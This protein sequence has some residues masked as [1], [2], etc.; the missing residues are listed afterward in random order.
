MKTYEV[1]YEVVGSGAGMV[2]EVVTAAS[3]YNA[4]RL[5][6]SK[7]QGQTV[8]IHSVHEVR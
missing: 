4:R 2:R 7:F 1:N 3:D 8:R 5:V 6:E